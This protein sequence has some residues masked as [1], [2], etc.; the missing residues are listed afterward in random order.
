MTR[1]GHVTL[2]KREIPTFFDDELIAL[3]ARVVELFGER[4]LLAAIERVRLPDRRNPESRRHH[5]ARV[6]YEAPGI[7][8][9]SVVSRSLHL[10]LH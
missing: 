6:I 5:P 8:N 1:V 3:D 10:R 9:R 2:P 7:A 4:V